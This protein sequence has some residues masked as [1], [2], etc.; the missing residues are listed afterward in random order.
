VNVDKRHLTGALLLLAAAIAYNLWAFTRPATS[1]AVRS[2]SGPAPVDALPTPSASDTAAAAGTID[3]TQIPPVPDVVLDRL[4][5]WPRNPFDN[6]RRVVEP[7]VL[8]VAP[9]APPVEPEIVV[10]TILYSPQRRLAMVNGRIAGIGDKVGSATIV[11]I[12][13]NAIVLDS[14]TRGRRIVPLRPSLAASDKR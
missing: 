3:P 10:G 4:P 6:P 11:D 1:S 2:A 8:E 7:A 13:P 12:E 5:Q 14:P 9:V